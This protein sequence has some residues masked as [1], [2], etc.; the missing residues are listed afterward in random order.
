MLTNDELNEVMEPRDI[1]TL[2]ALNTYQDMSDEEIDSII[3]YKCNLSFAQGQLDTET[4]ARVN[5]TN[6]I[7]AANAANHATLVSMVESIIE[8]QSELEVISYE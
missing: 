4:V 7:I 8:R 2:L 5:A 1:N 6:Q 3:D